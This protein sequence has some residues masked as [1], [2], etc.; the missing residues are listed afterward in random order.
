[1]DW[2]KSGEG[3]NSDEVEDDQTGKWKDTANRVFQEGTAWLVLLDIQ[4][5]RKDEN[6]KVAVWLNN[7]EVAGGLHRRRLVEWWVL[8]LDGSGLTEEWNLRKEWIKVEFDWGRA[9]GTWLLHKNEGLQEALN[10][11][12]FYFKSQEA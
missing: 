11:I 3:K 9:R 12:L 8:K 4:V 10:Y 6:W 7:T 5:V 2:E 1:M